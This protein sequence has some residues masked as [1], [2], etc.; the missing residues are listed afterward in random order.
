MKLSTREFEDRA[1]IVLGTTLV[2]RVKHVAKVR[3]TR[4]AVIRK[5][6][7]QLWLLDGRRKLRHLLPHLGA[8]QSVLD[9]GCGAGSVTTLLRAQGHAV[10]PLDVR[11]QSLTPAVTPILFDGQHIPFGAQYFDVALLLTVLHHANE[12]ELLLTEAARVAKR[13]IV[14]EDTY[15]N[16]PQRALTLATDSLVNFEFRGHPH[17][18]RADIEWRACFKGLQLRVLHSASWPVAAVFRQSLYVL[19]SE[20]L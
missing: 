2:D 7:F 4:D 15:S 10:T 1:N 16:R 5:L 14:I 6:L 19:E 12:P 17:N 13:V 3:S 18:N 20:N 11:A 9:I 8:S